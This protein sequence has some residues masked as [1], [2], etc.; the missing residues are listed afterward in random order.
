MLHSVVFTV[1][2]AAVLVASH[3]ACTDA[4]A[5][6]ASDHAAVARHMQTVT[7]QPSLVAPAVWRL[8]DDALA[9][10]AHDERI[11]LVGFG[12]G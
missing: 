5:S 12:C 10:A 11:V 4:P 6:T 9:N 3:P 2:F 7:E 8:P 1:A